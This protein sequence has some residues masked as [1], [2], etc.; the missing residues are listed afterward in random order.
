[1]TD[2]DTSQGARV[3]PSRCANVIATVHR[4]IDDA[5]VNDVEARRIS[6]FNFLRTNRFLASIGRRFRVDA[7]DRA[8]DSWIDRLR[9]LDQEAIEIELANIPDESADQLGIRALGRTVPR[10]GIASAYRICA[11][12]ERRLL[13]TAPANRQRLVAAAKVP[14]NYSDWAQTVGLFPLTSIPV[15][16]GWEQ[17]KRDNLATFVQRIEEL[18][19]KGRVV[20]FVP[21][22][23]KPA[24]SPASVARIVHRSR[25]PVLGIPTP[26]GRDRKLL[27]NAFAPVWQVDVTG[28]YDLVGQPTWSDDATSVNVD[29]S[30][31]TVFTRISH[32]VV[33]GQVLL[34]LN[35]SIWFQ[36][37]PKSGPLDGLA[38][39]LDGV[40]W[41][42]T[43]GADGR[44]LMYDSIHACGC[45]HLLFPMRQRWIEPNAMSTY[46]LK[47]LPAVVR[48]LPT[49]R[50]NQRIVLRLATRSHYLVGVTV[51]GGG[52]RSHDQRRTRFAADHSLRSLPLPDRGRRSLFGRDGLVVGTERLERFVLWPTG[53]ESPGAMRQWGHHAIAFA[54]RRHFDDPQLFERIFGE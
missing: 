22:G 1:M 21:P 11:E 33:D 16:R 43:L 35:Y 4:A 18:P 6:G 14:D 48:G 29:P 36:Q 51:S 9:A 17:W 45:Y 42:V 37:R 25:D 27:L 7:S 46:A 54:D 47:E 19:V 30:L 13:H 23:S 5:G 49:P 44:A 26:T 10:K 52:V 40:I 34:Q 31:P 20:S 3:S 50:Q 32:A 24:L 53:V 41:R 28:T 39:N 8:F 12:E 2:I 15:S 38:G